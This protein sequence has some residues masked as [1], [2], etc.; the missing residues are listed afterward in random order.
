MVFKKGAKSR[1]SFGNFLIYLPATYAYVTA[2]S[3]DWLPGDSG[4]LSAVGCHVGMSLSVPVPLGSP[5]FR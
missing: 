3:V 5:A 2:C 4:S 1:A